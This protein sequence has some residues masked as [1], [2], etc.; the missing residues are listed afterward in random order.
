VTRYFDSSALVKFLIQDAESLAL[1]EHLH[2]HPLDPVTSVLAVTEVPLAASRRNASIDVERVT[3]HDSWV[4][5]PW[6]AVLALPILPP[7]ARAAA[8]V[9]RDHGLR[10]LDAI[11]VAT[12]A[13]LGPRVD[14]LV[15]YDRR[16]IDAC[17][18]LGIPTVSPE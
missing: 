5:L 16:M 7:V 13:A 2:A 17:A 8:L 11:H 6:G 4:S 9:G 12:A 14:E 18:R 15:T 1:L 10:T 3:R